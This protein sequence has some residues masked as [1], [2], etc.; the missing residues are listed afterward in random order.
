M[1][2]KPKPGA[3]SVSR[4]ANGT[5]SDPEAARELG[6]LGAQARAHNAKLLSQF[7]MARLAE[8]S[9]F[10]PYYEAAEEF[11]LVHTRQLQ[12]ILGSVGS[13]PC[14]GI[15]TAGIAYALSR[16]A[17][18]EGMKRNDDLDPTGIPLIKMG[19]DWGKL[20]FELLSKAL[21]MAVKEAEAKAAATAR[22]QAAA[23]AAGASSPGSLA[24]MLGE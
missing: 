2:K 21:D 18:D 12:A 24:G 11:V 16:W 1:A 4:R 13:G 20:S 17:V 23:A 7:G 15:L 19:T 14:S 8:D 9:T 10:A 22:A 3:P 5:V 6:R